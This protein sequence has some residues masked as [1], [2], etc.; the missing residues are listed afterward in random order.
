MTS[1]LNLSR[2][3][4]GAHATSR[5]QSLWAISLPFGVADTQFPCSSKIIVRFQHHNH[6][7]F[8][9]FPY[10]NQIITS[11]SNDSFLECSWRVCRGWLTAET[12]HIRTWCPTYWIY[13]T[14][15]SRKFYMVPMTRILKYEMRN[16]SI[17]WKAI[18]V[19][20][21]LKWKHHH[22]WSHKLKLNQ[23]QLEQ[24]E[25]CW[26]KIDDLHKWK[27]DSIDHHFLLDLFSI[28]CQMMLNII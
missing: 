25:P 14:L 28:S 19:D 15:M 24:T 23:I 7:I 22:R 26:L 13:T 27:S 4:E 5:T 18:P 17:N 3:V 16:V 11:G 1:L 2:P 10:F 8:T 20:H 21:Q 12:A 6:L 9:F